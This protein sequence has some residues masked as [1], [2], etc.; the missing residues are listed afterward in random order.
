M[1]KNPVLNALSLILYIFLVA[2]VIYFG[3]TKHIDG[4]A[5][6]GPIVFISLFTFSAAMAGYLVL[7]QPFVMNFDGKKKEALD[8]F[9]K[10]L[11]FF[12]GFTFLMLA[13]L[14]SGVIKSK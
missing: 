8:L 1:T 7:Y 6:L 12:G 3:S 5:F 9:L 2:S 4:N 11:L 13:L 14:F 10:T